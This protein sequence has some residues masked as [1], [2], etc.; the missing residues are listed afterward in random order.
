VKAFR[1][2]EGRQTP[3]EDLGTLPNFT[4]S[5]AYGVNSDG[6]VVSALGA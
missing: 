1:W 5:G 2:V 4:S 3:M 6:T